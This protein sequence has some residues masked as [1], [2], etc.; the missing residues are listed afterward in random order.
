MVT[1]GTR[2]FAALAVLAAILLGAAATLDETAL[3]VAGVLAVGA[4]AAYGRL[5]WP[6]PNGGKRTSFLLLALLALTLAVL[7]MALGTVMTP[8][9]MGAPAATVRLGAVALA[10][11][12]L[13]GGAVGAVDRRPIGADTLSRA[14][15]LAAA[16]SWLALV[17]GALT[18]ES[19]AGNACAGFPLC[20]GH[21][22]PPLHLGADAVQIHWTHRLLSYVLVFLVVG[23]GASALRSPRHAR[24]PVAAITA[25]ALTAAQGVVGARLAQRPGAGPLLSAHLALG[26]GLWAILVVWALRTRR[27]APPVI[28]HPARRAGRRGKA[29]A[30]SRR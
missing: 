27:T 14:T 19:G 8:L 18:V 5:H 21:V 20:N 29:G 4:T 15:A 9:R 13:L 17:W 24:A 7:W 12:L 11:G 1:F 6:E 2:R 26:I 3:S 30:S 16:L 23:S 10:I 22:L 28:H 25:L